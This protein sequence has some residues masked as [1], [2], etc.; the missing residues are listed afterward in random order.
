MVANVYD[1]PFLPGDFDLSLAAPQPLDI[2]V[3]KVASRQIQTF[4]DCITQ[5]K[6]SLIRQEHLDAFLQLAE[7]LKRKSPLK[8]KDEEIV[9]P[10]WENVMAAY[11]I[12][13]T[14]AHILRENPSSLL[15]RMSCPAQVFDHLL[16]HS[17]LKSTPDETPAMANDNH[18]EGPKEVER[19]S[20]PIDEHEVEILDAIDNQRVTIIHGET[21]CGKSSRVPVMLL[22][23]PPPDNSMHHVKMFISQPRRIAAKSLVERV[24]T[25]EPDLRDSIALRMGHG[26]R[27]YENKKTR[28]WFVTTGYL[29]RLLANHPENFDDCSHLIIDEVRYQKNCTNMFVVEGAH[30]SNQ[31]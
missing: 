21:G 9:R 6:R 31:R 13:R 23:S 18:I 26:V 16:F 19:P 28:A 30:R 4:L 24:R 27:E 22:R 25:C 14:I 11:I 15:V 20:L 2:D 8:L 3:S 29:V 7:R 17:L 10:V 12:E 5:D 1:R